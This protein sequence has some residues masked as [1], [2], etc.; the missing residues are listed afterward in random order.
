MCGQTFDIKPGNARLQRN[1]QSQ[2]DV[3]A[4]LQKYLL[5]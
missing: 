1:P 4:S 2:T 5:A 3:Q